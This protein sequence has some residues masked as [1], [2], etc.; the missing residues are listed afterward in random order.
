M[1]KFT[2]HFKKFEFVVATVVNCTDCVHC[3]DLYVP[4]NTDAKELTTV[5]I[6][7]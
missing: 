5:Q 1:D 3:I 6:L 7:N 4:T 2:I